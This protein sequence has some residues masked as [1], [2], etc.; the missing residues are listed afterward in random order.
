MLIPRAVTAPYSAP[1][2]L[3]FT[4]QGNLILI[5]NTGVVHKSVLHTCTCTSISEII[6]VFFIIPIDVFPSTS[7]SV[8]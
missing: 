8:C 3:N 2:I 7:F 1:L 4:T 6:G 5:T